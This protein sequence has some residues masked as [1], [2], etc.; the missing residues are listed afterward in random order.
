MRDDLA[1]DISA[2]QQT[3]RLRAVQGVPLPS[4]MTAFR[5]MFSRIW[6]RLVDQARS[7]GT[8]SSDVLVDAASGIWAGSAGQTLARSGW[9]RRRERSWRRDRPRLS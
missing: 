1:A 7:T 4:V 6:T 9:P 8:V 5:V 2:A 3:G